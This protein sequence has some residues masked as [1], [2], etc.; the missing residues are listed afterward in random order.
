MHKVLFVP[1]KS[2]FLQSCVSSGISMVQLMLTSSKR[3]YA[4]PRS[5]APRTLPLW[6]A[7][8]ALYLCRRHK[9]SSGSVS[10][11][12]LGPG[13]HKILSMPSKSLFPQSCVS[14][15]GS[16][17]ELIEPPARG[18]LPYPGLQHPEPLPLQQATANPYLYRRHSNT[19][20]QVWLRLCGVP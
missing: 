9:H 18:L 17:V 1:S 19:Q 6:Q 16:M 14:S 8:A 11:G 7:T 20:R 15:G 4:I 12:T 3:T 5:A 13:V 10:V 2:L